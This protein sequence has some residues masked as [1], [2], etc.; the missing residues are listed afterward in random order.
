MMTIIGTVGLWFAILAI[1]FT[2]HPWAF[3][4]VAAFLLWHVLTHKEV[5]A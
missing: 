5:I 1:V 3:V 2:S 4:A